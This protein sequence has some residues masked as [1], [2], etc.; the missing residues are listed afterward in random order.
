MSDVIVNVEKKWVRWLT[1]SVGQYF[2]TEELVITT[3]QR[4]NGSTYTTEHTNYYTFE[5]WD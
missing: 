2:V 3:W 4:Q 1:N 5:G